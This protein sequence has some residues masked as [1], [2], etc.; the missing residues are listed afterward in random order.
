MAKKRMTYLELAR[1]PYWGQEFEEGKDGN[2]S[3]KHIELHTG[4]LFRIAD[5]LER[6]ASGKAELATLDDL[7]R[8]KKAF[9]ES[10]AARSL[11]ERRIAAYKG[12][13]TRLKKRGR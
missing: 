12:Q 11:L 2:I 13:I 4:L 6:T 5:A 1:S 8:T 10:L 3:A 7:A 9:N